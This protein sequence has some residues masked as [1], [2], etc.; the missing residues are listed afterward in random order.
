MRVR[1]DEGHAG[2]P[3]GDEAAQKRRPAG[4]V[5]GAE[6]VDTEDLAVAFCVDTGGNDRRHR[7]D[8]ATLAHFVEERVEPEIGV[9]TGI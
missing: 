6:N 1:D 8:P 9:G 2:E 7:D 3:P 5:F 4:T